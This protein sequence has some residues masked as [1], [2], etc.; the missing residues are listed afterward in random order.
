MSRDVTLIQCTNSKRST[1]PDDVFRARNLY[2]AS[3][4]F[5][6]MRAWAESHDRPWYILSAKHGLVAPDEIIAPYDERGISKSQAVE[7]A[8]QITGLGFDTVH[9]T[10]GRDYTEHLVPE[11]ERDG[12][13]VVNHFAGEPI[14]RRKQL[15]AEAVDE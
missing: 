7:I 5:T 1:N 11:I 8:L 2:D 9:I 3:D 15:L 10:A 12:V 4:Y 14:G 6:K 13:D